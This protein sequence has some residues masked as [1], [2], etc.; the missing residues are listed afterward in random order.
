ME[1]A[2]NSAY[3]MEALSVLDDEEVTIYFID[4]KSSSLIHTENKDEEYKL[5]IMPMRL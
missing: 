5:V 4:E 1:I 3:M 2:F